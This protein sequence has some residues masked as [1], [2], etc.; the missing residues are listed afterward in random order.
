MTWGRA[1]VTH[2]GQQ[3][4]PRLKR[5][6]TTVPSDDANILSNLS[7]LLPSKLRKVTQMSRPACKSAGRSERRDCRMVPYCCSPWA[8]TCVESLRR[9]P[10]MVNQRRE[11]RHSLLVAM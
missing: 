4:L 1:F 7:Q 6:Y 2:P 11:P 5:L 3:E 9:T 8:G 10:L